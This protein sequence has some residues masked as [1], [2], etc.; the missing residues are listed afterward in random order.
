MFDKMKQLA[1]MQRRMQEIKRQLD[2]LVFE[3]ASP[4]GAVRIVMNGSQEVREVLLAEGA[5]QADKQKLEKE[6][7]DT[8]NRAVRRS[9]ELAAQKMKDLAGLAGLGLE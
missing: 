3:V 2:E 5:C 9:Q 8:Y 6:L 4:D 7:R 1:Q